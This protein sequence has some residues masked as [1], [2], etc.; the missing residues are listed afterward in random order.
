MPV[1]MW[2]NVAVE[3]SYEFLHAGAALKG[4]F[5]RYEYQRNPVANG[6]VFVSLPK[7]G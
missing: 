5:S 4:G 7:G 3:E 6:C 1:S 2:G